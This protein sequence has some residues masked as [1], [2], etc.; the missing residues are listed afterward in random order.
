MVIGQ[1]K[2]F[3]VGSD[4]VGDIPLY[5]KIFAALLTGEFIC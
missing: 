2:T 3:L 4:F 1:V 5:E